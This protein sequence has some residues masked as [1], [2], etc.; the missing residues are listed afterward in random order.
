MPPLTP[1]QIDLYEAACVY[2]HDAH[3]RGIVVTKQLVASVAE[4]LNNVAIVCG[5]PPLN[6]VCLGEIIDKIYDDY[7]AAFEDELSEND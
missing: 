1:E 3:D 4:A 5:L 7:T 2:L 6:A